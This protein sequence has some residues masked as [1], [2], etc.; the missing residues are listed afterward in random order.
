VREYGADA[1]GVFVSPVHA[2]L[3][4]PSDDKDSGGGLD[5]SRG[6]EEAL[7]SQFAVAHILLSLPEVIQFL[8]GRRGGEKRGGIFCFE[9]F[10]DSGSANSIKEALQE[11]VFPL[12]GLIGQTKIFATR[13]QVLTG[14]DI[15]DKKSLFGTPRSTSARI[16]RNHAGTGLE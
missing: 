11:A 1:D 4:A 15:I 5:M 9:A 10:D 12:H 6:D 14:V 2:R 7:L 8:V 3:F 16:G 13:M